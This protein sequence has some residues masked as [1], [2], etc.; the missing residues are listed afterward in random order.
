MK[1]AEHVL[2]SERFDVP[3]LRTV[4]QG[5][6]NVVMICDKE[7]LGK[8]FKEG[9]LTIEVKESFYG[10]HDASVEKCIAALQSATI[11]NLL[12]SIIKKAVS[13]GIIDQ[14]NVIK[15]QKVLHAQLIRL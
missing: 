14:N 10:G 1:P 2:L 7:L 6:E 3:L 5:T 12:G 11:A 13:A 9:E 4:Q 15:I 8:K